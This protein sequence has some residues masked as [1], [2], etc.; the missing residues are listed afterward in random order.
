MLRPEKFRQRAFPID[1]P[2][3]VSHWP[4]RLRLAATLFG[5]A[6]VVAAGWV[7]L[8]QRLRSTAVDARELVIGEVQRSS[9]VR[10]VR[11]P[12]TLVPLE[13]RWLATEVEGRV[14][15]ILVQAGTKVQPDTII[16]ELSNPTVARSADTA[17]L[18]LEVLQARTAVLEMRLVNELLAQ[19]A[20]VSEVAASHANAR[21][22]L[23]ANQQLGDIVP[24]ADLNEAQL[25]ASQFEERLAIEEERYL[26]MQELQVAEL[27]ANK[28]EILRA[29]GQLQLQQ[30][31]LA[32]LTVRAGIEGTLQEVPVQPGQLLAT[33][34]LLARVARDD[35]FKAEL[36][37]Q[38]GQAREIVLGQNVSISA[39][40][41]HAEGTV[42][43][44]D[45]AVQ[46][47]T[48]LVDVAF[49]GA[50]LSGARPDLRVQGIIEIDYVDDTLVLPRPV[51]SQE[52]SSATLFVL[53][54]DGSGADKKAV[55]LGMGS[56]DR[57]QVLDGLHEGERVIVSDMSRYAG[58]ES[59]ELTGVRHE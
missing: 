9:L 40:G 14:E 24:R 10:D 28:A 47:G 59:I 49:L 25:E 33:G 39:G 55:G 2:R 18:E 16:L 32:G 19:R 38:E 53:R 52:N 29:H 27:Q 50:P 11:A 4:R 46:E 48:V 26:R 43:R 17:R 58:L 51:F 21:F 30:H 13:L 7:Y 3:K 56:V 35:Q 45:P 41:Q 20:V 57:I 36:R 37:V 54:A 22:R 31:L 44:I 23:E 1:I 34:A 6:V 42:I 5:V 12:G 8:A 15:N